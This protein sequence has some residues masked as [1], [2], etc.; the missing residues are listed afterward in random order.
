MPPINTAPGQPFYATYNGQRVTPYA[1][2]LQPSQEEGWLR[3]QIANTLAKQAN[4]NPQL[5]KNAAAASGAFADQGQAGYGSMT[6]ELDAQR[7]YLNQLASGQH[8]VAGEQ[9][10]QGMQQQVA[11]QRSMAASASPQNAAMAARNAMN[12]MARAGYGM[13]GQAA[14]AGLQERQQAQQAL[15]QLNLGQRGQDIDVANAGRQN[16]MTGLG[17]NKP[18]KPKEPSTLE[19]GLAAGA[20]ISTLF[21]DERLKSNIKGGDKAARKALETLAAKTYTYK[22]ER[23]GKGEQLGIIA[24]DLEKVVPD[25]IIETPEGKAVHSGKLAGA[26]TAMLAALGRRVAKLEKG[27]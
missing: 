21:S 6:G 20:A 23:H 22:S 5:L 4:S 26:N 18:D 8:S 17:A 13:S 19:K 27:K 7:A 14:L 25:A 2:E 3:R 24:Q 15:A 1:G 10:R 9:L 16:Q 12:N 11:A